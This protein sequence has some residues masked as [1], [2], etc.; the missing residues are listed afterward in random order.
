MAAHELY[1]TEAEQAV[2]GS[3]MID[4]GAWERLGKLSEGDFFRRDHRIIFSAISHLAEDETPFDVLTVAEHLERKGTLQ[5]VGDLPYLTTLHQNTPSAANA[6]RYASIVRDRAQRR[7]IAKILQEMIG[8]LIS[9]ESASE[10]LAEAQSR[11]ESVAHESAGRSVDFK[12]VI[13]RAIEAVD[14]AA[15]RRMQGGTVGVPTGFPTLDA[16]TG[17]FHGQ[18]LWVVAAR[19]SIGKSAITL[20]MALHAASRG[21]RVGI[22]SLEMPA[23]E[24]GQRALANRLGINLTKLSQ[25]HDEE[26]GA[27]VKGSQ[28]LSGF[29]L[30]VDDDTYSLSGIISRITEWRRNERINFAI[31]DHIGLVEGNDSMN[32][33]DHLGKVTRALKKT[34]KRMDMP[35]VA[36]SQLSRGVEKEKRLPKL[37]D[38]RD[39]GSIEQDADI[40]MFLHCDEAD[41]EV[42]EKKMSIGLLKNRG[43]V[44]GWLPNLFIFEGRTQRFREIG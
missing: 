7:Q 5:D 41:E 10:A 27:V 38:L 20:Q 16:R 17:G 37:S 44:R 9:A 14:D 1:S 28:N 29:N 42:P 2:L 6:G 21:H 26:L 43:G 12:A 4:N 22:V 8:T 35:I 24:I 19:P 13:Q 30:F 31:V 34:A 40:C 18:R 3:L 11:L 36:V 39:S 32:R 23:E 15:E 33:N 25:G